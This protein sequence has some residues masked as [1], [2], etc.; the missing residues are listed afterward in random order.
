MSYYRC[1]IKGFNKLTKPL[2]L[3]TCNEEEWRWE[4]E[5]EEA[6]LQLKQKLVGA[7]ILRRLIRGRPFELHTDW[8]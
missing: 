7:P 5:H 8:S 6:F 2:M 3:L 1:Y 4:D